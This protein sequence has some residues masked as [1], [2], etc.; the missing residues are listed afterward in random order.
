MAM[1]SEVQPVSGEYIL[2]SAKKSIGLIAFVLA[3]M[4]VG[5][6]LMWLWGSNTTI[7]FINKQ[8]TWWGALIGLVLAAA[9][10]L[11]PP[12]VL[13]RWLVRKERLVFGAE[14]LQIVVSKGGQ[15]VVKT[16]IAF[17]NIESAT[18]Q[19]HLDQTV[20]AIQLRDVDATDL[21][22]ASGDTLRSFKRNFG[23]HLY[24]N[25][26]YQLPAQELCRRIE[27]TLIV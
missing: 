22:A 8:V 27:R 1:G 17:K 12:L 10:I 11:V 2:V 26:S 25:D 14:Y 5:L 4:P 20:V 23:F 7:P 18:I 15:D 16:Q 13:W 21:V 24:L 3:V 19:K 9:G 6:V